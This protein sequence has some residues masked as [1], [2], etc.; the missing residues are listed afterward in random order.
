MALFAVSSRCAFAERGRGREGAAA[1]GA[2]PLGCVAPAAPVSAAPIEYWRQANGSSRPTTAPNAITT[3]AIRFITLL[4][5]S[6]SSHT[7]EPRLLFHE[8]PER[9]A[10]HVGPREQA[11]DDQVVP[12]QIVEVGRMHIDV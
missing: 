8:S 9:F 5:T 11:R 7:P 1:A 3:A 6:P 10:E 2:A 12:I 4:R